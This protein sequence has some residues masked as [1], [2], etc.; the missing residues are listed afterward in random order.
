MSVVPVRVGFMIFSYVNN[1]TDLVV[2]CKGICLPMFSLVIVCL[3]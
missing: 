3:L 2:Y 1:V